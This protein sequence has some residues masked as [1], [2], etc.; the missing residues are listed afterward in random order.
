MNQPV[1]QQEFEQ[2]VRETQGY[3]RAYI[4]GIGVSRSDVDDLAQDVYI[5]LYKNFG[6]IP[7]EATPLQW[8]KGIARNLCLSHFRKSSRRARLHRE[9]LA[10]LLALAETEMEPALVECD[11]REALDRC[12]KKLPD[13]SQKL[14]VMCYQ[15][16]MTSAAMAQAVKSTAEAI[17]IALFRIRGSLRDCIVKSLAAE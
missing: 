12:Y 17:R 2:I 3:V 14:L 7:A 6:G 4:A 16:K 9:A 10:D 15:Q 13:K 11:V 1:N 8:L 5:E